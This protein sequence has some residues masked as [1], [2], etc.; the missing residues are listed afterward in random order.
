ML[1]DYKNRN[2]VLGFGEDIVLFNIVNRTIVAEHSFPGSCFY[3]FITL[4]HIAVTDYFLV[5]C[6]ISVS[7]ITYEG[8]KLWQY[9]TNDIISH[10][11]ISD[12]IVKLGLFEGDSKSISIADGSQII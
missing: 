1:L 4:N 5:L 10:V 8:Q 12:G 9:D 6:E 2:I 7:A 11:S 3:Q